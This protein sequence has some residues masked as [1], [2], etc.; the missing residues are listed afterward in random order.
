MYVCVANQTK[1]DFLKNKENYIYILRIRIIYTLEKDQLR[2][3]LQ[4]FSTAY[5]IVLQ[6]H[7]SSIGQ[8]KDPVSMTM[9]E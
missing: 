1:N 6:A 4:D 2:Y 3:I 9:E 5:R 8:A 7:L